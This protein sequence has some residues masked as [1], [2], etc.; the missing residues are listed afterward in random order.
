MSGRV[1]ILSFLLF[2]GAP[3]LVS[4]GAPPIAHPWE[5]EGHWH[6]AA[7]SGRLRVVWDDVVAGY[8]FDV[9][10]SS[11]AFI[12]DGSGGVS[13]TG[14]MTG[15]WSNGIVGFSVSGAGATFV[16]LEVDYGVG[17]RAIPT[18]VIVWGGAAFGVVLFFFSL[19]LGGLLKHV[20]RTA[21]A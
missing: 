8:P 21:L 12:V 20:R 7:Y 4:W 1:F 19:V 9:G 16:P 14:G 13:T 5:I 15:D 10:G 17:S 2:G 3:G 11:D 6:G 18:M